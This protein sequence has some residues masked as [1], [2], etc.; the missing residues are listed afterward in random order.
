MNQEHI[1]HSESFWNQFW[2]NNSQPLC[3]RH[4]AALNL[5]KKYGVK[6]L[7]DLGSGDGF[8]IE[9]AKKHGI[10]GEGIELSDEGINNSFEKGITVHKIDITSDNFKLE[11]KYE[12]ATCLDVIEHLL[13]PQST[14]KNISPFINSYLIVGVPNFNSLT[15]RF[16]VFFGM[17]PDNNKSK[18]GHCYWFNKNELQRILSTNGYDIIEWR[19]NTILEGLIFPRLL[20]KVLPSLLALSFV[21]IAKK[22]N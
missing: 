16:E 3:F 13:D 22:N 6:N 2:K 14:I 15:S 21:V 11:K 1:K 9:L 4:R 8:F 7:L 18:I 20:V 5:L 19:F 10:V 17:I 12:A